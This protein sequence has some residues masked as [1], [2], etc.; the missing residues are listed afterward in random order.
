MEL[1]IVAAVAANRVI[2]KE[3]GLPW[4]VP[5]E[6][7]QYHDIIRGHWALVGRK[8]I[9]TEENILPVAGLFILTRNTHFTSANN[10]VVH[11]IAEAI[12]RAQALNLPKLFI[13]GGSEVYRQTLHLA[14]RMIIS[15]VK[16]KV[17]GETYFPPY[18]MEDWDVISRKNYPPDAENQYGFEVV[19]MVA[20]ERRRRGE[21]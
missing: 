9:V 3:G 7:K 18:Q 19:E 15:F 17:E 16:A 12:T 11:T 2:G 14:D 8:S 5:A 10:Q 13:L 1:V 21:T 4:K 20:R 6:E